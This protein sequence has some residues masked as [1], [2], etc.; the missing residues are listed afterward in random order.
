MTVTQILVKMMGNA[1]LVLTTTATHVN[2]IDS[3]VESIVKY[4]IHYHVT[5]ILAKIMESANLV[6]ITTAIHVN[7]TDSPLNIWEL[8]GFRDNTRK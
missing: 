4:R 7:V 3:S 1:N 5:P 8:F 2:V 6:M